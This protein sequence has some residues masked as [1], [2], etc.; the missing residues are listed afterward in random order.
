MPWS[1]VLFMEPISDIEHATA[2]A[3][4][5]SAGVEALRRS[6]FWKIGD[7]ELLTLA[8][9]LERVG[10]LVY[11]A[12]VHLTGELDTRRVFQGNGA[13]STAALLRQRLCLS[14]AEAAGRVRAARVILPRDLPTG[15]EAPPALPELRDAVDSGTVGTEQVRT[16]IATMAGLPA[17]VDPEMRDLVRAKLVDHAKVTEPVLFA[18]FAR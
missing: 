2:V 14:P 16:V 15:G 5:V 13:V 18:K 4:S 11:A 8:E 6:A 1:N 3:G 9:T 10:R 7:K 12:Q 17:G